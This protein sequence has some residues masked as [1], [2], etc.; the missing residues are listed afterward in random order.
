MRQTGAQRF[1]DSDEGRDDMKTGVQIS[2]LKPVL[3]TEREVFSAFQRVAGIGSR[4]TQLQWIDR[5]VSVEAIARAAADTDIRPV[6]VQDFYV[7]VAADP[8]YYIDLNQ[9]TGG[10]WLCVSRIPE[11][12]R[13]SD[14][15]KRYADELRGLAA[16]LDHVKQK[17]CFHPV[18]ADYARTQDLENPVRTLMELMP[19][20]WLCLDLYHVNRSG[21]SM[22]EWIR[23]YGSRICM[24]HFKDAVGDRLV[25][26]GQGDTDWRGVVEACLDAEVACAFVEQETWDRDPF[27]CLDEALKWLNAQIDRAAGRPERGRTL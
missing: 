3:T 7:S 4:V 10:E 24:V 25:P 20:L 2:S 6:S 19:E 12:F 21:L 16:R 18:K 22:T 15:L 17:L 11:P 5:A 9:A 1:R 13:S 14:G 8:D 26:A 27:V 23:A